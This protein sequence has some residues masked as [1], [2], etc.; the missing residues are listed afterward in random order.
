MVAKCDKLTKHPKKIEE[1]S[2]DEIVNLSLEETDIETIP[3]K[4]DSV[5]EII[6]F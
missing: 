2:L 4:N 1:E 5:G 6:F 3:F